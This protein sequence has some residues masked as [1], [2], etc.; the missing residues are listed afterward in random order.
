MESQ[1]NR[2]NV[3]VYQKSKFGK[4]ILMGILIL[5]L[6]FGC[7][8]FISKTLLGSPDSPSR[9]ASA[10]PF[11][12]ST[13]FTVNIA[14]TN[15]RRFLVTQFSVEVENKQVLEELNKK[16]PIFQ[17]KVIMV[18]SSQT[19]EDLNSSDG[20]S[21]I[22]QLLI[23]SINEILSKGKIENIFFNKFVYQ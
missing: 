11:Y 17:D 18:L 7:A 8:F 16:L 23:D 20:K 4:Y 10:G 15:G 13:E 2:N 3:E 1:I 22:K 6:S 5:S 9:Q 14:D 19:I 21:Q 12:E